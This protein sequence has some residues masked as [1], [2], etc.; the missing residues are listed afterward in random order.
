MLSSPDDSFETMAKYG[1]SQAHV[2]LALLVNDSIELTITRLSHAFLQ[3]TAPQ[4]I[5]RQAI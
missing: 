1:T 2:V 3:G 5:E 4:M